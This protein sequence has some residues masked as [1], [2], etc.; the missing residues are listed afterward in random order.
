MD[1]FK[2]LKPKVVLGIAAHPDDLDFGSAGTMAVFAEM[3]ADVHYIILTDGSKGSEDKNLSSQQLV[4]IREKEQKNAVKAIGGKSVT[5][6][7]YPD[8]ELEVTMPL[9]KELVKVIRRLKPDVVI[10]MDP[11]MLYV[12]SR[13]FINHPDHRAAGQ[14]AIDAVFPL[15]RDHLT[16][17]DLYD[18]GYL[19]HKTQTLLL[20]NLENSN[21]TVDITSTFEKKIEALKAHQSQLDIGSVSSWIEEMANFVGQKS[22]YEKGE[23]FI[24][25]DIV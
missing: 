3:G 12:A 13:G 17:P 24:R 23:Q 19:P 11:S 9:K 21:F 1:N 15:S 16:F 22:G 5:F 2:E 7:K 14:A 10:T 25:I 18:Q 20:I 8:A 4:K 6:P